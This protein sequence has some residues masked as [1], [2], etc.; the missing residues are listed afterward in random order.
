[1]IRITRIFF[2]FLFAVACTSAMAQATQST[3]TTSS[4]YSRYGLGIIDPSLLPQTRA[5]GGIG[6]AVNTINNFYNIN[7][8]NP[9]SYGAIHFT[10]IDAGIYS[11]IETLQQSGS[12]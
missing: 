3:A 8:L 7:M 11:N 12:S 4:P 6:T 1:M 2:T 9:A 10:V 5:M